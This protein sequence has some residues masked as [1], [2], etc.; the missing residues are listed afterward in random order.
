VAHVPVELRTCKAGLAEFLG[1]PIAL[2][3]DRERLIRLLRGAHLKVNEVSVE[4]INYYRAAPVL[5]RRRSSTLPVAMDPA[6][7]E[8]PARP[9]PV[10]LDRFRVRSENLRPGRLGAL[11]ARAAAHR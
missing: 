8:L 2:I 4:D 6:Q 10:D 3:F 9:A 11:M 1:E 5:D 7:P